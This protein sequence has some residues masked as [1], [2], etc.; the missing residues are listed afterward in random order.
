MTR[1]QVINCQTWMG[2]AWANL[3]KS[4]HSHWDSTWVP[5]KIRSLGLFL[6]FSN[7]AICMHFDNV[8][9]WQSSMILIYLDWTDSL[10]DFLPKTFVKHPCFPYVV[11]RVGEHLARGRGWSHRSVLLGGGWSW[12]QVE[13]EQR[14][15]AIS[16]L[17]SISTLHEEECHLSVTCLSCIT[18]LPPFHSRN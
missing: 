12:R 2:S 6:I 9:I 7:C 4:P 11:G 3:M 13:Y 17:A 14:R 10:P 15:F 16:A 18:L 8:N 5:T 1:G